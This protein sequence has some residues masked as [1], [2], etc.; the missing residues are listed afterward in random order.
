ME[1]GFLTEIFDKKNLN[2]AIYSNLS[3]VKFD[4]KLKMNCKKAGLV[5]NQEIANVLMSNLRSPW[6]ISLPANASAETLQRWSNQVFCII[7]RVAKSTGVEEAFFV[8]EKRFNTLTNP[9]PTQ[10]RVLLDPNVAALAIRQVDE[11]L[12]MGSPLKSP[13]KYSL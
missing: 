2:M 9:I 10:L 6:V 13:A 11:L 12:S 8:S 3:P 1:D 7:Q 5:I 4:F